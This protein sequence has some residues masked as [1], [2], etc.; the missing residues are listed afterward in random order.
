MTPTKPILFHIFIAFAHTEGLC[1]L[2][3][4]QAVIPPNLLQAAVAYGQ[5]E[6]LESLLA[7][8]APTTYH[9]CEQTVHFYGSSSAIRRIR[10]DCIYNEKA[11]KCW[12]TSK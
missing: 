3:N 8:G 6:A 12:T 11:K 4:A 7:E 5:K 1:G 10:P 2:L 9:A